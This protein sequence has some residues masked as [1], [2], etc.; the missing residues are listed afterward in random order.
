MRS[1]SMTIY[2]VQNLAQCIHN[3]KLLAHFCPIRAYIA[4]N[5]HCNWKL[6]DFIEIVAVRW[7][8][9]VRFYIKFYFCI[10]KIT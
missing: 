5:N 4:E 1:S 7:T 8:Y 6:W 2:I 3:M 10:T 9:I